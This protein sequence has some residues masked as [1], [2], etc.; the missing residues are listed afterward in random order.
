MLVDRKTE[1]C[2]DLHPNL[3]YRFNA[4]LI[5]MPTSYSADTRKLVVKFIWR[6]KRPRIPNSIQKEKIKATTPMLLFKT[7]QE[8]KVIKAVWCERRVGQTKDRMESPDTGPCEYH[9]LLFDKGAKV[10]PW[11]KDTLFSKWF[12]N[13]WTTTCNNN[14]NNNNNSKWIIDLNAKCKTVKLLEHR[15]KPN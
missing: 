14:N 1:F 6:G 10:M 15:I 11:R 2:Q 13:N 8:T 4:I 7:Y 9:R 3:M 12:W 5:K